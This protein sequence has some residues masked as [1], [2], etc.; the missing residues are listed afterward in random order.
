MCPHGRPP[1]LLHVLE[2]A[3][4]AP[5]PGLPLE[6]G[7]DAPEVALVAE[8]VGLLL[9]FTPELDG[10]AE[11]VHGLA[12]AADEGAAKVDVGEVV[13]L[14]LEVGDLADVVGDGVQEGAGDVRAGEGGVGGDVLRARGGVVVLQAVL[15][16]GV[17]AGGT[18]VFGLG[19]C[20][21]LHAED[22]AEGRGDGGALEA[23][24][25]VVAAV[26]V[27]D[28]HVDVC[29]VSVLRLGEHVVEG[30]RAGQ[31]GEQAPEGAAA[32]RGAADTLEGPRACD[33]EHG[34]AGADVDEK[35]R[36]YVLSGRDEVHW[37]GVGV[38]EDFAGYLGDEEIEA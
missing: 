20:L 11:G 27:A 10:V 8:E 15:G 5:V 23:D 9:A 1:H 26:D 17:A 13:D 2:A 14:G 6:E 16:G 24:L 30:P 22:L 12:V 31:Q 4:A 37:V 32:E 29:V 25:A 28:E 35:V 36:V 33:L 34:D 38:G 21:A 18:E 3:P 7:A 19:L